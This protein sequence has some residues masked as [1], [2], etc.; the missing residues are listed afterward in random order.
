MPGP[1]SSGEGVLHSVG[2]PIVNKRSHRVT[3]LSHACVLESKARRQSKPL[4]WSKPRLGKAGCAPVNA[5]V[6]ENRRRPL[7]ET[8]FL[9][10]TIKKQPACGHF[11][12]HTGGEQRTPLT[13]LGVNFEYLQMG[14][15]RALCK[16][17]WRR[18]N[19]EAASLYQMSSGPRK[20]SAGLRQCKTRIPSKADT[21]I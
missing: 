6:K 11:A 18:R 16:Q 4:R 7:R 1:P 10:S 3:F 2:P 20:E 13:A 9:G 8:P 15:L 14:R 21:I 12:K 17:S 5:Q 19:K